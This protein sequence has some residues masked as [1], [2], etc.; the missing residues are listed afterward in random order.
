MCSIYMMLSPS[1]PAWVISSCVAWIALCSRYCLGQGLSLATEQ[2]C[3]RVG[4]W[5]ASLPRGSCEFGQGLSPSLVGL[6]L[7]HLCSAWLRP[8]LCCSQQRLWFICKMG[9]RVEAWKALPY[10]VLGSQ[11]LFS[12]W[13]SLICQ[14]SGESFLS[15]PADLLRTQ[16]RGDRVRQQMWPQLRA[17]VL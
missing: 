16:C 1:H 15:Q 8:R 4:V 9:S 2:L 10:R 12:K 5:L 14:Q 13:C 6:Y 7:A 3:L 17:G 11:W